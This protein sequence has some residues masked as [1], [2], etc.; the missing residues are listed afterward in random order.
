VVQS[1]VNSRWDLEHE[2]EEQLQTPSDLSRWLSER[3]LLR[4]D[5]KLTEADLQRTLSAREGLRALLFVNNGA[6]PDHDAIERLNCALAPSALGVEFRPAGSPALISR[7]R[8]LNAALASIASI[9][10]VAQIDGAW[11]RLKACPGLHCGWAF[12]DNSRNQRGT[13]CS[14]ST[15]GA[16]TKVREYR[17]RR[18]LRGA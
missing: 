8:D 4:R 16:R 7:G 10:A 15:C 1:F 12:Y 18:R 5:R 6:A 3:G 13:W 11:S 9:V 14:M 17:R 2:H